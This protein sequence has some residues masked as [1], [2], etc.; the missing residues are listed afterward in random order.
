MAIAMLLIGFALQALDGDT[1]RRLWAAFGR[2]HPVAQG[3]VAAILLT[4]VLGLGPAGVAP[5]IYFQF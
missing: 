3:L 4:V 1:P 5:F 2:L